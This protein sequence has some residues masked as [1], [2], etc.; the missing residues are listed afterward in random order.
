MALDAK[1]FP[2]GVTGGA[3]LRVHL[4]LVSVGALRCRVDVV[5]QPR[6]RAEPRL[7]IR[8]NFSMAGGAVRQL[9]R[10]FLVA[11]DAKT[12]YGLTHQ[13]PLLRIGMT[14][15]AI[16]RLVE[17][18]CVAERHFVGEGFFQGLHGVVIAG[19]ATRAR[20]GRFVDFDFMAYSA[21]LVRGHH[22]AFRIKAMAV[23]TIELLFNNMEVVVEVQAASA[24]RGRRL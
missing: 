16:D 15:R 9:R 14:D 6:A 22:I 24:A 17:V 5:Y 7:G 4:G 20:C 19:V 23:D 21:Q 10:S 18:R 1:R 3:K 2:L 11:V 12:H 13:T 8:T